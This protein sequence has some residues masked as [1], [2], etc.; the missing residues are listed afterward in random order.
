M[1]KKELQDLRKVVVAEMGRQKLD[2]VDV[3]RLLED[4]KARCSGR[5]FYNFL[6]GSELGH[7]KLAEV[8]AVLGIAVRPK[9]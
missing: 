8:F 2:P 3:I 7:E 6:A 5:V 9:L 1:S 4:R